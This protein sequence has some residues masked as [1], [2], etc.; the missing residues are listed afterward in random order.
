MKKF[1]HFK[2][3]RAQADYIIKFK[4]RIPKIARR[5]VD[6]DSYFGQKLMDD[7]LLTKKPEKIYIEKLLVE[8]DKSYHIWGKLFESQE[9]NDIWLPKVALQKIHKEK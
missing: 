9:L 3:T 2:L 7:K 4:D 5:W 6:L 8:K 1:N